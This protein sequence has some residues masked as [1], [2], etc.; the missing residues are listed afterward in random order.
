[1]LKGVSEAWTKTIGLIWGDQ[2]LAESSLLKR[3]EKAHAH[4]KQAAQRLREV[5]EHDAEAKAAALRDLNAWT[6]E[7]KRLSDESA[8]KR[9]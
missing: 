5:D 6:A 3:A 9:T 7:C 1:M 2:T 8:A 4:R